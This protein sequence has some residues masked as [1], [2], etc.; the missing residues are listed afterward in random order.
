M[1]YFSERMLHQ[2]FGLTTEDLRVQRVGVFS[3]NSWG[4]RMLSRIFGKSFEYL[5]SLTDQIDDR[6][7]EK[8]SSDLVRGIAN[9]VTFGTL[10]FMRV[11]GY[12]PNEFKC[13]AAR[14]SARGALWKKDWKYLFV[15]SI[16]NYSYSRHYQEPHEA[17]VAPPVPI[18]SDFGSL[19][20]HIELM[21][22]ENF[23][24]DEDFQF[25]KH[26]FRNS[27]EAEQ[28]G[29]AF[30]IFADRLNNNLK[31]DPPTELYDQKPHRLRFAG[32]ILARDVEN[33][34]ALVRPLYLDQI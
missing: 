29:N 7:D 31:P 22:E 24:H 6:V 11:P 32:R 10:S 16:D 23:S 8:Q 30:R 19:V 5:P 13:F 33:H 27:S 20:Y 26:R 18:A 15:G 1:F 9:N 34:R 3:Q 28:V 2:E 4:L 25:K 21:A 17:R 12:P 14:G